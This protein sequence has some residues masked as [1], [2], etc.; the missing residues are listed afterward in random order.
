MTKFSPYL[1]CVE[2]VFGHLTPG[3]EAESTWIK[4]DC[5]EEE[6]PVRKC[7]DWQVFVLDPKTA[8]AAHPEYGMVI[9][10]GF[11]LLDV[12]CVW[13]CVCV[14]V[15]VRACARMC[16]YVCVCVCVFALCVHVIVCI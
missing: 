12:M 2:Q 8:H 16:V 14:R 13:V 15:C 11:V 7:F 10:N 5:E 4:L 9:V 6:E 1:S 3:G